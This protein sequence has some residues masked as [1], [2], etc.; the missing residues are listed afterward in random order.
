[1]SWLGP[2]EGHETMDNR[3]PPYDRYRPYS[4]DRPRSD[5]YRPTDTYRPN[6]RPN[7]RDHLSAS[8][9]NPNNSANMNN[10]ARSYTSSPTPNPSSRSPSSPGSGN[11][12]QYSA[13]AFRG[14]LP[15]SFSL[16]A[17][18][19]KPNN[20]NPATQSGVRNVIP[21]APASLTSTS[22]PPP[23]PPPRPVIAF[24]HRPQLATP[25][26]SQLSPHPSPTTPTGP[27][28]SL[29]FP[30]SS[31]RPSSP[32]AR[33]HYLP[34]PPP[35]PPIT[36]YQQQQNQQ[37]GYA[38]YRPSPINFASP[39]RRPG[40]AS[41]NSYGSPTSPYAPV[42]ANGGAMVSPYARPVNGGGYG[43]QL[44]GGQQHKPMG[45]R[46]T[47]SWAPEQEKEIDRYRDETRKLRIEEDRLAE[48]VRRT[49]FELFLANW[50]VEKFEHQID[51]VNRQWEEG[52]ME[53]LVKEEMGRGG[54]AAVASGPG[55]GGV[56]G[57][58]VG[59][60]AVVG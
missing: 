33:D 41:S 9:S 48:T 50:E 17:S 3:H 30:P 51:L 6:E 58:A 18:T 46:S 54:L 34:P 47:V 8:N 21:I 59:G 5:S 35:P 15:G 7:D 55:T 56:G 49:Q 45:I 44:S 42:G 26:P 10:N 19:S 4:S 22:G 57:G 24:S 20:N 43:G 38:S 12:D 39:T 23:P 37:Q 53:A 14:Q 2:R 60:Q 31:Y 11:S 40:M 27:A 1:M 13:V 36:P 16:S 25:P 28:N 52:G 29:P 32:S